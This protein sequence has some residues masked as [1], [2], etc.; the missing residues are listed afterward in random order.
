MGSDEDAI[1]RAITILDRSPAVVARGHAAS[2]RELEVAER[3][4]GTDF[5]PSYRKFLSTV[6]PI[7]IGYND[8]SACSL[9]VYGLT[10]RTGLPDVVWSYGLGRTAESRRF[11]SIAQWHL[12]SLNYLPYKWFALDL[13]QKDKDSGEYPITTYHGSPYESKNE[14]VV[15]SFG[16][17]LLAT[18]EE[19][20]P[21]SVEMWQKRIDFPNHATSTQE[22]GQPGPPVFFSK[23]ACGWSSH[24]TPSMAD[25][26][27]DGENHSQHP[28]RMQ[29]QPY[30]K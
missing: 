4:I 29:A 8:G 17:W 15:Q 16:A 6:G 12:G 28:E 9:L 7:Q 2:S 3:A 19:V 18:L 10:K 1:D 5:P 22:Y 14:V 13:A 30:W 25:A 20:V 24:L 27:E 26:R 23:C 11:L 21:L